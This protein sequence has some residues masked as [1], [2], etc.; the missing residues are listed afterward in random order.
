MVNRTGTRDPVLVVNQRN[1]S[2]DAYG[3]RWQG[4]GEWNVITRSQMQCSMSYDSLL[5]I[6]EE[7]AAEAGFK[8]QVVRVRRNT[9]FILEK[10]GKE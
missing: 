10:G 8:K 9:S 1:T 7:V 6:L 4:I 2:C 5:A 3:W